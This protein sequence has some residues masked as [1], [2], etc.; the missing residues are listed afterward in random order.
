MHE[1]SIAMSLIDLASA[2]GERHGGRVTAVYIRVGRLSGVVA[3]ALRG[4]WEMAR[5]ETPLAQARLE[6]EEVPVV[7]Y[8]PNCDREVALPTEQLF[9]CTGCGEPTPDVRRGRELEL[10]ALE[11]E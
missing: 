8:C 11:I 9:H 2:E 5:I 3:D 7:V 6:I 1:L 4:S 10:N